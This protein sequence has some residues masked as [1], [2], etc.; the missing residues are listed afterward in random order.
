MG[1]GDWTPSWFQ[2]GLAALI[3]AVAGATGMVTSAL[4]V[5][6]RL[7][8]I[9]RSVVDGLNTLRLH[10]DASDSKRFHDMVGVV[11]GEAGKTD[12]A[13]HHIQQRLGALEQDQ[14]VMR[15][16]KKRVEERIARENSH[17]RPPSSS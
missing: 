14:A 8:S 2:L 9:D 17:Q 5:S 1:S 3:A 6:R 13:L 11:Q 12:L 4:S 16:F 7:N 10:V 15:D